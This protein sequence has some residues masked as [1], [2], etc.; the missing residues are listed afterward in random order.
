MEL[1]EGQTLAAILSTRRPR[2]ASASL[3]GPRVCS[4][5]QELHS[6]NIDAPAMAKPKN[7]DARSE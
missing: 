7:I 6:F 1:I 4:A 3:L 5:V 2:S